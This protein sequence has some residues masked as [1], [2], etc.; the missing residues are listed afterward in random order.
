[1][2]QILNKIVQSSTPPKN[3]YD[4]WLDG[5]VLRFFKED[6]WVPVGAENIGVI[7]TVERHKDFKSLVKLNYSKNQLLVF[8]Q[9]SIPLFI[10][11]FD[12]SIIPIQFSQIKYSDSR[13]YDTIE[14]SRHLNGETDKIRVCSITLI[15]DKN[16]EIWLAFLEDTKS[17]QE[18]LQSG[19]NIKTINGKSILGAGDLEVTAKVIVDSSL[20][21]YSDNPISNKAIT[22]EI[23]EI[24]K[25]IKWNEY[26]IE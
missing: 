8:K 23:N 19:E 26:N 14:W 10:K 24:K 22:A 1:M 16:P 13:I 3:K 7:L 9:L 15:G 4:L 17:L 18:A 6:T 25:S 2:A 21:L 20:N 5:T 12:D 11:D